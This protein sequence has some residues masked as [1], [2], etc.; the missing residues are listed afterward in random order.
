MALI[1]RWGCEVVDEML[2][3]FLGRGGGLGHCWMRGTGGRSV[4]SMIL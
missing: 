1:A 4:K 2:G 3:E